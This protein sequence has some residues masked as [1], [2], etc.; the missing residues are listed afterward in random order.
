[1]TGLTTGGS[2]EV[3][4]DGL[5]GEIL[6]ITLST[7][8]TVGNWSSIVNVEYYRKPTSIAEKIIAL[9]IALDKLEG[10]PS[11]YVIFDEASF[12]EYLDDDTGLVIE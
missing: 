6:T 7:D 1:L 8:P 4:I 5:E 2:I 3:P 11:E 9:E 10:Y 12:G